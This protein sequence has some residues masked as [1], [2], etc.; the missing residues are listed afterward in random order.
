MEFYFKNRNIT[1]IIIL[2]E[3]IFKSKKL[4]IMVIITGIVLHFNEQHM[5]KIIEIKTSSNCIF[6]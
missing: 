4:S 5:A 6:L 2:W 1:Q 3:S